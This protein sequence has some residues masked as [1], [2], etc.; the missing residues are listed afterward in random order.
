VGED[1]AILISTSQLKKII[2]Q[3]V[4]EGKARMNVKGGDNNTSLGI[5]CKLTDLIC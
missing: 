1:K 5:L 3:L 4:K 2:K